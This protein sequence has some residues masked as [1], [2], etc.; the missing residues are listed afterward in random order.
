MVNT[1]DLVVADSCLS[2]TLVCSYLS[3][4]GLHLLWGEL[5]ERLLCHQLPYPFPDTPLT[6]MF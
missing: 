4:C 1:R 2:L 6:P 5:G 3:D